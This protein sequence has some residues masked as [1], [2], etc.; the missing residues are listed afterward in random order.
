MANKKTS[1]N[2]EGGTKTRIRKSEYP[3]LIVEFLQN[4]QKQCFN[5]KQIA[6]GIGATHPSQRMDIINVLDELAAVG[7]I[8]EVDL[9][10]YRAKANRGTEGVGFFIRRSNG[11]NAVVQNG[12]LNRGLWTN[13]NSPHALNSSE[14][15]DAFKAFAPTTGVKDIT[16]SGACSTDKIYDMGGRRLYAVPEH[17][18][19]IRGNEKFLCKEK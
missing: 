5:Y 15:L 13:G 17:G 7:D 4:Q 10:K 14:A 19:Y 16:P 6:F 2:K 8:V 9:G 18:A 12:W 11:K 1:Q 3:R